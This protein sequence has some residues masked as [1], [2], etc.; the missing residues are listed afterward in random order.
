MNIREL[1]ELAAKAYGIKVRWH[2]SGYYGPTMEIM[3]DDSG[4]SP[5]NPLTDDG[6]ALRLAVKLQLTICN[7]H[8][9]SGAA[10]CTRGD[11]EIFSQAPGATNGES[12]VLPE[13]YAAT[14][15]A[16][17]LAASEIGKAMP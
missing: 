11:S 14:R 7:E 2:D 3:E 16:I 6:D 5:W 13:D 4:G 1:L 8:V 12:E 9:Q 10:Y 15:I 17:V